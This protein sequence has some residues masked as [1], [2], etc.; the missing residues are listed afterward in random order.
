M[1]FDFAPSQ[2]ELRLDVLE[3]WREWAARIKRNAGSLL[4]DAKVYVYNVPRRRSIEITDT[5]G[6]M[7]VSSQA[8]PDSWERTRLV[9]MVEIMT[10]LNSPGAN[11]FIIKLVTPEEAERIMAENEKTEFIEV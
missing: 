11:P 2:I 9:V 8:P 4:P 5:I 1:E 6:L 7:I 10:G 3:N